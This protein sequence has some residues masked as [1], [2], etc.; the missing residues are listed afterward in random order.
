MYF[1]EI[2]FSIKRVSLI[3]NWIVPTV[4]LMYPYTIEFK[5]QKITNKNCLG[6]QIY[7]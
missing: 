4:N 7:L 2:I 1:V 3:L 5:V 6:T